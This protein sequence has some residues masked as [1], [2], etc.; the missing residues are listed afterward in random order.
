MFS[1]II[2]VYKNES[3][4]NALL[5]AVE[6]LSHKMTSEFE[7]VFVIDGSPDRCYEILKE[8][9]PQQ[10]FASQLILLSRNFGSFP[11]IRAGL[12]AAKGTLFGVMAADLQE[13]PSLILEME[14][15]LS[16]EA[17][18]VVV[19]ARLSREDPILTRL[20]AQLFWGIYRK[21]IVP[22][23]PEG[24][25]DV[26]ACNTAFRDQLLLLKESH[27][28]LIA[29]IFWLG[30][31]RKVIHYERLAR[32]H[33]VS[34]WT[35]KKKINYMLD[36]I[37]AFTDLPIKLLIGIGGLATG[38][39]FLFGI[40]LILAKVLG[41][42]AVPGYVMTILIIIFFGS[43]NLLSFGIIGSY[44][45]RTYENTKARPLTIVLNST[46]FAKKKDQ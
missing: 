22:E 24:G 29:Q 44:C 15:I 46:T 16:Q 13:P 6:E 20:P 42:I 9:L 31:K 7:A 18:D 37:F 19:A 34:A 1:L 4:L 40:I 30:F 33:G 11:A 45:W 17:I 14:K 36:S 21:F 39:A 32:E 26:F 28:S 25:I 27:S 38:S 43:L 10:S 12:E 8:T 2:P 41:L 35:L 3:G 5:N 23:M